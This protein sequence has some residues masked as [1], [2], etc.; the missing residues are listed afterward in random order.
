MLIHLRSGARLQCLNFSML[1]SKRNKAKNDL[2]EIFL[3]AAPITTAYTVTQCSHTYVHL[4]GVIGVN[5]SL[6]F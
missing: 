1:D 2:K 3:L 6:Q 5:I 4:F